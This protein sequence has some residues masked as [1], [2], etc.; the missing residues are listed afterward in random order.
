MSKRTYLLTAFVAGI[1]F[2]CVLA[3]TK[4]S[5]LTR[6]SSFGT[7][8]WFLIN[9]NI[10][11]SGTHKTRVANAYD[12]LETLKAFPNWPATGAGDV[13]T[14]QF[15]A[16]NVALSNL[17][18]AIGLAAT[19]YTDARAVALSNLAYVIG[20]NATNFTY[21][22]G[23]NLTNYVDSRAVAASNLSYAIGTALTNYTKAEGALSTN[24]TDARA[25]ALSNLC[26]VI[27]ANT[28]NFTYLI[29]ANLTNYV[30]SRAVAASNLSYAIGTA[31]TNYANAIG[32]AV[33]NLLATPQLKN[34]T[35]LPSYGFTN[36]VVANLSGNLIPFTNILIA[37]WANVLTTNSGVVTLGQSNRI[38]LIP[39]NATS[40]TADFGDT[41]NAQEFGAWWHL[42]TN[43]VMSPTNL[44][45]G[46]TLK[47]RFPTN[48]LTYDVVIT[49]TAATVVHWNFNV[50][51][52]GST[53]FTKTNTLEARVYITAETNG[54]LTAEMGYYR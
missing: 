25:V 16:A 45:V 12:V 15:N 19:N 30:D 31:S 5:E 9:T 49:N 40:A 48:S 3:G 51:T 17:S 50:A 1:A 36:T 11:Q 44:V 23:G 54:T 47:L 20:A 32:V 29:G 6:I 38:V 37:G 33:S 43:L 46:R 24:Y 26:Y 34:L 28:T 39:T 18:Y 53:S 14:A 2:V 8:A 27:G 4:I 10:D 21:L 41:V 42:T 52:N 22:I 7:N 35:N 13:T